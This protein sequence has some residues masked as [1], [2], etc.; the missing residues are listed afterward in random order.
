MG[1]CMNILEALSSQNKLIRSDLKP[2]MPDGMLAVSLEV[3]ES[4]LYRMG[5]NPDEFVDIEPEFRN[6]VLDYYDNTYQ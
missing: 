4:Q 1:F 3:F 6:E 2:L 5:L